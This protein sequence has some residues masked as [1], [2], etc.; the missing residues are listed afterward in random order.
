MAS[1]FDYKS[2]KSCNTYRVRMKSGGQAR[3]D[4]QAAL[5][6]FA[7]LTSLLHDF[8]TDPDCEANQSVPRGQRDDPSEQP[9]SNQLDRAGRKIERFKAKVQ[10]LD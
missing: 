9:D 10:W 6:K 7:E 8:R 4:G 5:P 3:G 2:I 1:G